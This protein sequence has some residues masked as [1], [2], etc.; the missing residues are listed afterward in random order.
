LTIVVSRI[1]MITP[2]VTTAATI[3]TS[4]PSGSSVAVAAWGA[5]LTTTVE[6]AS[7]RRTPPRR[8]F[9]AGPRAQIRFDA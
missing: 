2:T 3:H 4:R 9:A 8:A 1:D 6:Y 5:D 7:R